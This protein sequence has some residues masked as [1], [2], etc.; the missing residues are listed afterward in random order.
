MY[1]NTMVNKYV[2]SWVDAYM[3]K[4]QLL[5]IVRRRIILN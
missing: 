3:F 5:F 4:R 2:N 1:L